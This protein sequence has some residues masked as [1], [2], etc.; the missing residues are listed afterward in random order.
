[1]SRCYAVSR[2]QLTNPIYEW[3]N[4]SL[5][6]RLR[7]AF[8]RLL[9]NLPVKSMVR[10]LIFSTGILQISSFPGNNGPANKILVTRGWIL[11][12]TMMLCG[13]SE[14]DVQVSFFL[15]LISKLSDNQM[16][17]A[18]S[19]VVPAGVISLRC[20][21]TSIR[22]EFLALS[23]KQRIILVV[24]GVSFSKSVWSK[25]K[26]SLSWSTISFGSDDEDTSDS[27][28]LPGR[29]TDLS[30]LSKGIKRSRN[31]RLHY[32]RKLHS[33]KKNL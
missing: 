10:S 16:L 20:L 1:M 2:K 17:Q 12:E 29:G 32:D 30:S 7:L 11:A 3:L 14:D 28:T 5:K 26:F 18:N 6:N 19:P 33:S 22:F 13:R 21:T 23:A 31:I 24:S 4:Q 9:S 8:W 27:T 15:V 25:W